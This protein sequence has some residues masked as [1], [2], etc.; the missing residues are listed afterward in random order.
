MLLVLSSLESLDHYLFL[1]SVALFSKWWLLEIFLWTNILSYT[2]FIGFLSNFIYPYYLVRSLDY[3][4]FCWFC[5]HVFKMAADWIYFDPTIFLRNNL[6]QLYQISPIV[7]VHNFT[8]L[9]SILFILCP[10]FRNSSQLMF[11]SNNIHIRN[12]WS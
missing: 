2:Q 3:D 11:W 12:H 4:L 6:S 7:P 5:A 8:W 1:C 9:C 10:Y